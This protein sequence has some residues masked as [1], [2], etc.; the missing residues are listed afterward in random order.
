MYFRST[1]PQNPDRPLQQLQLLYHR[2]LI[3]AVNQQRLLKGPQKAPRWLRPIIDQ[4]SVELRDINV[5]VEL[6]ILGF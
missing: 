6:G 3:F 4:V 1:S 2:L 5:S